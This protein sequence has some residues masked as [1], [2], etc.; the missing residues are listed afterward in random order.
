MMSAKSV[1]AT[2]IACY[3]RKY[4]VFLLSGFPTYF[5]FHVEGMSAIRSGNI[6]RRPKSMAKERTA[7]ENSEYSAKEP[8]GPTT[9]KPG[10]MLLKQAVT[11]EKFA[12]KSK[13]APSN[14]TSKNNTK[15]HIMYTAKYVV[16]L[17]FV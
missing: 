12:S 16:T 14:E 6:S 17:R 4:I 8:A 9:P 3:P 10:P 1:C 13:G 7:F 15:K 5:L 2:P 11:A